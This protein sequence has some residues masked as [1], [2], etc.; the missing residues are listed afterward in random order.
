MQEKFK[1]LYS[2][3]FLACKSKVKPGA[4]GHG[5]TADDA[6]RLIRENA[7]EQV[8]KRTR[9]GASIT[10]YQRLNL[11]ELGAV[12]AF[13]QKGILPPMKDKEIIYATKR[14]LANLHNLAM[15]CALYYA[16]FSGFAFVDEGGKLMDGEQIRQDAMRLFD[17]KKLGGFITAHLYKSWICP[18]INQWLFEDS[19][20]GEAKA[21]YYVNWRRVEYHECRH[22]IN[23]FGAMNREIEERYTPRGIAPSEN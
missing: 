20:R 18:K 10:D 1:K 21:K 19:F 5:V 22:L 14:M 23:R 7:V 16:D 11:S 17:R 9:G 4:I 12:L 15:R 2:A 8:T 3:I 6:A 13:V